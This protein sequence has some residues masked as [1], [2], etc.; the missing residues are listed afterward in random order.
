MNQ[1]PRS[2][3]NQELAPKPSPCSKQ[4][5]CFVRLGWDRFFVRLGWDRNTQNSLCRLAKKK[6]YVSFEFFHCS[7]STYLY[8]SVITFIGIILW[9][10]E[11][12]SNR[13]IDVYTS[14]YHH[15]KFTEEYNPKNRCKNH[16]HSSNSSY[17]SIRFYFRE[18]WLSYNTTINYHQC[19]II[20]ETCFSIPL[21][22]MQTCTY[23]MIDG[24]YLFVCRY[25]PFSL[26]K[27]HHDHNSTFTTIL[28][29]WKR[30]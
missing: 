1:F 11:T 20:L 27:T 19:E 25:N 23:V 8:M 3:T 18:S 13:K 24:D 16:Y 15:P 29:F 22:A 4:K 21:S 7:R 6:I 5:R 9:Y 28:S 26:C 14:A 2:W 12:K 10:F 30:Q 17:N